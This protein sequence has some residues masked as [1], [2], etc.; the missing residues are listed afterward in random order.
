MISHVLSGLGLYFT[1]TDPARHLITSAIGSTVDH[2]D[3]DLFEV[4]TLFHPQGRFLIQACNEK[5]SDVVPRCR[6]LFFVARVLFY[7]LY[8]CRHVVI[9]NN[10]DVEVVQVVL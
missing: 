10:A 7:E 9:R 1:H 4:L 6:I 8:C 5:R 2:A 3:R